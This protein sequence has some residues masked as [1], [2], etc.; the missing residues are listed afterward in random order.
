MGNSRYV[1]SANLHSIGEIPAKLSLALVSDTFEA[2]FDEP[3]LTK[4]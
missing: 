3:E 2:Y 1:A 4:T